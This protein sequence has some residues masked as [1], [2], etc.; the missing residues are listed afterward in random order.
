MK[1][2]VTLAV[3]TDAMSP[4]RGNERD[5]EQTA[6]PA[7]PARRFAIYARTARD[8]GD[9]ISEQVASARGFLR[10]RDI[11]DAQVAVYEDNGFPGVGAVP[12]ALGQLLCWVAEGGGG[13]LVLR[14]LTRLSRDLNVLL[15]LLR[16]FD[17]YGVELVLVAADERGAHRSGHAR[18]RELFKAADLVRSDPSGFGEG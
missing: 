11:G 18:L 3:V 12:P 10:R 8:S 9:A 7:T 17:A 13:V 15:K 2:N 14:D 16:T 1:Y 6:A 4:R 5:N